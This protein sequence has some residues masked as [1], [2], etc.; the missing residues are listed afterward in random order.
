[1]R[2]IIA[3]CAILMLFGCEGDTITNVGP[4]APCVAP[5]V[6]AT[7]IDLVPGDGLG[8][9]E[10]ADTTTGADSWLWTVPGCAP[11]NSERRIYTGLCPLS[12]PNIAWRLTTGRGGCTG[13]TSGSTPVS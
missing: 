2:Q 8:D 11:V 12:P 3:A 4:T 1:M 6:E 5:V 13:D 9:V 7:L 10:G